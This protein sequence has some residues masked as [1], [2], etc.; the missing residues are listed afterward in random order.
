MDRVSNRTCESCEPTADDTTLSFEEFAA[1]TQLDTILR[2][3]RIMGMY[4]RD[5]SPI[6]FAKWA[7]ILEYHPERKIVQHDH[8]T[9]DQLV[10]TVWLGH[11]LGFGE[12]PP[13]IFETM[14]FG[15]DGWEDFQDR[16]RTEAEAQAGHDRVLAD[17]K[18][19]KEPFYG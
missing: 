8:L 13:V 1:T 19:G 9:D 5:G 10:S 15:V 11:D 3:D 17:I 6:S 4:D 7:W 14:V 12:G 16:Y 18:A 2:T